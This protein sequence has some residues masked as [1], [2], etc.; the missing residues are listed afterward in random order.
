MRAGSN[1]LPAFP[2][3]VRVMTK[4]RFS[5]RQTQNQQ[6][7]NSKATRKG[8]SPGAQWRSHFA[9]LTLMDFFQWHETESRRQAM[10]NQRPTLRY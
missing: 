7:V 10:N 1:A 8:L 9:D 6:N 4:D 2:P 3:D 5:G